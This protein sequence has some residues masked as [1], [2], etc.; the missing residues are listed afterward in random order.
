MNG[1]K[2]QMGDAK[3]QDMSKRQSGMPKIGKHLRVPNVERNVR[4]L[5]LEYDHVVDND[6]HP[7][8]AA[9]AHPLEF[10]V[11]PSLHV[12]DEAILT[13]RVH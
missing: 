4:S 2:A 11:E 8:R 12:H 3:V 9:K 5:D 10:D 1:L 13:Q 7:K 6:V